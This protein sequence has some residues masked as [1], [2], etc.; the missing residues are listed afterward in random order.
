MPRCH[1]YHSISLVQPKPLNLQHGTHHMLA[2]LKQN[3]IQPKHTPRMS[4][5]IRI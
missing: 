4:Y 3:G 1:I 2:H 5:H